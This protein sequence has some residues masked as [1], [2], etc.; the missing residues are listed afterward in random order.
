MPASAQAVI[1]L[2]DAVVRAL[3][4]VDVAKKVR[5]RN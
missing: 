1:I 4:G 5:G 3:Q 2:V